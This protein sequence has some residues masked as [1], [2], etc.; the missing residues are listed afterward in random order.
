MLAHEAVLKSVL[1][2]EI[3][4]NPLDSGRILLSS[5]LFVTPFLCLSLRHHVPNLLHLH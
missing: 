5:P 1:S 2:T 4:V 3:T